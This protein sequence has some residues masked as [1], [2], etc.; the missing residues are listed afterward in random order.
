MPR[1][2]PQKLIIQ[3]VLDGIEDAEKTYEQW[4]GGEWLAYSA[5]HV[6]SG[7][8]ARSIMKI[9]GSQYLT[10]EQRCRDAIESACGKRRGKLAQASRPDG[11][12]D[13]LLWWAKDSPRAVVEIKNNVYN[14]NGQCEADV[15]RIA[16]LLLMSNTTLQFGLFVFYSSADDGK[17]KKA[18]DKLTGRFRNVL[19]RARVAW[20]KSLR[21][22]GIL[23]LHEYGNGAWAGACIIMKPE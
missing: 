3:A 22:S 18:T 1:Q 19:S 5:E 21:V 9:P 8:V 4:S 23:K 13:L 15:D 16:N 20:G 14:Y 12:I 17:I 7:F 11:R 2:I 10:I 6:I